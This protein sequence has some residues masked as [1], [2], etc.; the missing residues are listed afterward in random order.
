MELLFWFIVCAI[1]VFGI[2]IGSF[3]NCWIW[4]FHAKE[5]PLRGRSYCPECRHQLAWF[6]LIP[7]LSFLA[8]RGKCRYCQKKISWQY[9]TVEFTAGVLFVAAA[10]VFYPLVFGGYFSFFPFL[11]LAARW[12]ILA[13]LIVVFVADLRWYLIPDSAL[14]VGFVG[15]LILQAAVMC[16]NYLVFG[17]IDLATITAAL[18]P[19]M[20]A[21][22][23]FLAIFLASR[24]KWMGFGDVKLAFLMG[25][26]LDF[27]AT[28]IALFLA[29]FFGAIIGLGLICAK[30]KKM[31]SQIPFG[32][33]L[34]A[35]TLIA[36][37]FAPAIADWYLSVGV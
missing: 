16:Q 32:P 18:L 17:Q 11:E 28:L 33:F 6:D 3:L 27:Y 9:P 4:R 26:I 20:F 36:L 37:F 29:N 34:V 2:I 15:A 21:G 22:L 23:L 10:W 25:F 13:A 12:M 7:V 1:F 19:V 31:S 14:V 35:G 5:S 30:K 24:G 8:I